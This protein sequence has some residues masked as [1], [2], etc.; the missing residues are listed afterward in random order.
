MDGYAFNP[1]SFQEVRQAWVNLR[2][3]LD[4]DLA[5]A[6]K[7]AVVKAPGHEPASGFVARDQNSSGEALRNSIIQMQAFVASYLSNLTQAEEE[8]QAQE[9]NVSA[10][11]NSGRR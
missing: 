2:D 7:L 4:K 3:G 5:D 6:Q 1:D 11:M 9:A 10:T 8:Y